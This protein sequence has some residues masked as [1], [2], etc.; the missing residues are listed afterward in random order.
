V[1]YNAEIAPR[2]PFSLKAAAEFGFAR[3]VARRT[4]V[5]VLIRLAGDRAG[6]PARSAR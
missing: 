1:R 4:W 5:T 6:S 2:G 3:A